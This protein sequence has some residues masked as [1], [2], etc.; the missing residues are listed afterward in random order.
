MPVLWAL[1]LA[2]WCLGLF[3]CPC[4]CPCPTRRKKTHKGRDYIIL[5]HLA[6]KPLA[7][8]RRRRRRGILSRLSPNISHINHALCSRVDCDV[9]PQQLSRFALSFNSIFRHRLGLRIFFEVH[10]NFNNS[11]CIDIQ[12]NY[13]KTNK[14]LPVLSNRLADTQFRSEFIVYTSHACYLDT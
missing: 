8:G 1:T 12:T 10:S 7:A 11:L 3:A 4:P 6:N 13:R 9:R 14:K 5:K 2:L